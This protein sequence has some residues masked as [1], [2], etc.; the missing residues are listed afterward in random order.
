MKIAV[1]RNRNKDGIVNGF[2]HFCPETYGRRSVQ[3][4]I[5]A[6][7]AN[8]HTVACIEGDKEL[9]AR[10]EEFMPPDPETGQ[11]SGMVFNMSYGIQGESRYTHVPGMLEMAGIPYTGSSPLGHALSLDKV[12]AKGLMRDAGVPTPSFCVMSR[13]D[14]DIDGLQFPLI[15]KPRR[16]STSYGLRW[17]RNQ[18]ELEGA[19]LA[20]LTQYQQEA[21]VEEYVDGREVCIGL[22]GNDTIEFLPPVELDFD[23]RELHTLTW[24][25]KYH[26]SFDEPTKICPAALSEDLTT[27]LR[28]LSLA[29]FRACHCKDYARVDI[30]IDQSGNPFVLEI[31]SM[32]S[33]GTG[34]AFV[35]AAKNAG[36]SFESLVCR[37]VDI[38][39]RRYFGIPAMLDTCAEDE[40][41]EDWSQIELTAACSKRGWQNT[42]ES[43][44]ASEQR[45]TPMESFTNFC[46][47]LFQEQLLDNSVIPYRLTQFYDDQIHHNGC[48]EQLKNIVEPSLEE[49]EGSGQLDTS[50]EHNSTVVNGLQHKYSQTALL[51]VT[52][53]CFSYCRFCFRK[54]LVGKSSQEIVRDYAETAEY[55]KRHPEINNILISG[56]DPFVLGTDQLNSILDYLLKIPHLTSIR[57]GTKAM[58]YYP[59]RFRDKGLDALFRRIKMAGKTPVI[60][61]HIE[62]IGEI[63]QE[64]EV[65]IKRL[66]ELG[67]QFFNQ[68]VLLRKVNDD[69]EILAAT[70]DK[71]HSLGVRPYYLFQARPVKGTSHFQVP[72]RRGLEIVHGVNRRLSGIQKTFRYIMSHYTGKIEIISISEDNWLYMRYHQHR[73]VWKVGILFSRPYRE[74]AC[75]LDD[76]PSMSGNRSVLELC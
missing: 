44:T 40:K 64:T 3:R 50:G 37:I 39:H 1:V 31:N 34:G 60:V 45:V 23:G 71:L 16:E 51:L 66:Y 13:P 55:I 22:L 53:K 75:W 74:G 11:A 72:L 65:H 21:L 26:K 8:G 19:V 6:L 35:L 4:V 47:D 20:I 9:I 7:R 48:Y 62:H 49:L 73:D 33:L 30:R 12:I 76:L 67:V 14:D 15:V 59:L 25:D 46:S 52:D 63:S 24:E 56:G 18:K 57:F 41:T 61:T 2:G 42:V 29:T 17:V 70:F 58:V 32:A 28:E 43:E 10:L 54:R 27:R 68:T 69:S 38:T 5:D 36:Y